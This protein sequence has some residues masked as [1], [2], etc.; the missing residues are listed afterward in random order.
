MFCCYSRWLNRPG[1]TR[2]SLQSGLGLESSNRPN[3]RGFD[4][5]HDFLADMKDDYYTHRP[6]LRN[7]TFFSRR[8]GGLQYGGKMIEA[9]ISGDWKLLQ[10][11]PFAPWELFHLK[12]D[13]E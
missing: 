6:P 10:D 5:F 9:V 3:E 7:E 1:I 13:P 8:E 4:L 12:Q 11:S 2:Q